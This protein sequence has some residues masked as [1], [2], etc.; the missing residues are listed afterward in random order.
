MK[1]SKNKGTLKK[2]GFSLE[3]VIYPTSRWTSIMS[4][5]AAIVMMLLVTT[6]VFMRRFLNAPITGSYEIGQFLLTIVI[7]CA[8]A[9]TMSIKGHVIADSVTR[10]YPRRLRAAARG[11]I[12]A[13]ILVVVGTIAWGSIEYGLN[14]Y[15]AGDI[16][17]LLRVPTYPFIFFAAYGF[18]V[19]FFT[20]L[21]QFIYIL[22]GVDEDSGSTSSSP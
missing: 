14:M 11:I 15:K 6:D 2:L 20:I 3:R 18:T 5:I 13:L 19:L 12:F 10:L 9:Y 21:V 17:M 22:A 8:I 1:K 16:S 4:M 7:F